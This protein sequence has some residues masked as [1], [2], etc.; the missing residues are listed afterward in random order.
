M[1]PIIIFFFVIGVAATVHYFFKVA[2][3]FSDL[4]S[5]VKCLK[6][7]VKWLEERENK[8]V[9]NDAKKL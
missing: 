7:K 4:T 9:F 3:L 8:R 2:N 6:K 5:E 1:E